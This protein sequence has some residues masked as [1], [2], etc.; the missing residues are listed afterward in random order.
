MNEEDKKN[1]IQMFGG[2]V[3]DKEFFE[4]S[5]KILEQFKIQAEIEVAIETEKKDAEG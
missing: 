3:R 5:D 1:Q 4:K 2:I